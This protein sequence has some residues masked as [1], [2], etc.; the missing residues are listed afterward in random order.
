[1]T[2][3]VWHQVAPLQL[4]VRVGVE[5]MLLGAMLSLTGYGARKLGFARGDRIT[6]IF[7]GSKKSLA[8]GLSMATVLFGAQASLMVLP[9]TLFHQMHLMVCAGTHPS[10]DNRLTSGLWIARIFLHH[11]PCT[12]QKGILSSSQTV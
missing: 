2:Q 8:A 10:V 11:T 5:A 4:V 6:I 3:G 12:C 1:M 7:C 9:L